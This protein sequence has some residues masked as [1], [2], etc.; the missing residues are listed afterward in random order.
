MIEVLVE[1]CCS[2]GFPFIIRIILAT[3]YEYEYEYVYTH[4][5]THS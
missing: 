3:N 5:H 1:Y 2:V 4:T